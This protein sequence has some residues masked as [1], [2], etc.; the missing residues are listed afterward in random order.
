MCGLELLKVDIY[1]KSH[2]NQLAHPSIFN[3]D[4]QGLGTPKFTYQIIKKKL[5]FILS[6]IYIYLDF[7]FILYFT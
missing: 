4:T 3:K 1:A 6:I 2:V 5:T 7:E